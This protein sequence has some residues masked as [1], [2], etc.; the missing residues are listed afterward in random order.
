LLAL[1]FGSFT[2]SEVPMSK[3]REIGS[4][5][6]KLAVPEMMKAALAT[7]GGKAAVVAA[8][9]FAAPWLLLGA[10]GWA[11]KKLIDAIPD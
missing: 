2:K 4:E 9:T 11:G 6:A 1:F 5:A 10:L 8:A 7:P 3:V